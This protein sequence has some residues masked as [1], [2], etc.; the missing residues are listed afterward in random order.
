MIQNGEIAHPI[1]FLVAD[2]VPTE[3]WCWIIIRKYNFWMS[4][5]IYWIWWFSRELVSGLSAFYC[6]L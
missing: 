6:L 2:G 3:L 5:S 1:A 4:G